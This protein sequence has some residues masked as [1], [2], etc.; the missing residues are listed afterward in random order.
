MTTSVPRPEYPRPDRDRSQH[1]ASLN[2]EWGFE[3]EWGEARAIT[4]PFAWETVASG[5]GLNWLERA[6]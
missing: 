5:V 6:A 3:P 4:V 1:W 2:G